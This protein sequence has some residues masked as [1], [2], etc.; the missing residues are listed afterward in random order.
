MRSSRHVR[1]T[2]PL[3][4]PDVTDRPRTSPPPAQPPARRVAM[5]TWSCLRARSPQ[6]ASLEPACGSAGGSPKKARGLLGFC[7][8]FSGIGGSRPTCGRLAAATPLLLAASGALVY[9]GLVAQPY[10]Q[11]AAGRLDAV[12]LAMGDSAQRE[13]AAHFVASHWTVLGG[14]RATSYEIMIR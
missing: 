11:R 13:Q 1:A 12:Q 7:G 8:A 5:M 9:A 2:P 6:Y 14:L 3:Q 10:L 4:R